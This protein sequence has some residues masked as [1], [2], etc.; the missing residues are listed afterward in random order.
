MQT[1]TIAFTTSKPWT[2]HLYV[3]GCCSQLTWG[4]CHQHLL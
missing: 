1:K 4:S 2:W 3:T